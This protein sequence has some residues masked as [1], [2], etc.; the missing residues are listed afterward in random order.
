MRSIDEFVESRKNLVGLGGGHIDEPAPD[1]GGGDAAGREACDDAEVLRTRQRS[2][3][4][5]AEA[6]VIEP[7]ARTSS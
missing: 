5:D 4:I 2:G 6:V 3:L 7:E 1:V